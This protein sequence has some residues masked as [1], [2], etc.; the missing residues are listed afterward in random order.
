MEE[1]QLNFYQPLLSVRRGS[2]LASQSKVNPTKTRDS[3]P[4]LPPL[5]FYK[6]DLKSGPVRNPGVVPFQWEQMPGRPKDEKIVPKEN[7]WPRDVAPKLPPGRIINHKQK[8]MDATPKESPISCS[9]SQT[10]NKG[11]SEYKNT[12]NDPEDKD[13][14]SSEDEK[15]TFVDARDSLS[16]TESFFNCSVSGVSGLDN[17]SMECSGIFADPLARDFM[18][19]RF[20][21][22]AKAVASETPHFVPRKHSAAKEQPKPFTRVIKWKQQ[23]PDPPQYN[24][25]HHID[26]NEE[27]EDDYVVTEDMSA[28]FCGLLPKFCM[29]NP[30]PGIRDHAQAISSVRSVRTRPAYTEFCVKSEKKDRTS[31]HRGDMKRVPHQYASKDEP[32]I[33]KSLGIQSIA[34]IMDGS[35][36][37]F[38]DKEKRLLGFPQECRDLT[39][40]QYDVKKH[41]ADKFN[42]VNML[43][44]ARE[45]TSP[46]NPAME[47]MFYIDS[48]PRE[49]S[50][51]SI[52]SSSESRGRNP[53]VDS[54]QDINCITNGDE[55]QVNHPKSSE[56][57][58]CS[59]VLSTPEYSFKD[60]GEDLPRD[61]DSN[62]DVRE[63]IHEIRLLN[64]GPIL[65]KSPSESW[66]SRT[67]PSMP[68]KN[69]SSKPYLGNLAFRSSP[70][71]PKRERRLRT[72]NL[73][74]MVFR[75]VA[76]LGPILE[77]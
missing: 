34:A 50:R 76:E 19:G 69:P 57:A 67:L 42:E 11:L 28:K 54:L 77:N 33:K 10:E 44:D 45:T 6:S 35:P 23:S 38:L 30:I 60:V 68:T 61:Q 37:S 70:V 65:P 51:N 1:R 63:A 56:T 20:L 46:L 49:Q 72:S 16:R 3:K 74:H 15:V 39:A 17:Q 2:S 24:L 53:S 73:Q 62:Q 13:I 22:A 36:Q 29:L 7:I 55:K 43:Q 41:G 8:P 64:L 9:R 18:M 14:S 21:P 58:D 27:D 48:E 32:S 47:K 75:P 66:L 59:S 26:E 71:D 31:G 4:T 12:A 52:S 5:P 40:S 25:P